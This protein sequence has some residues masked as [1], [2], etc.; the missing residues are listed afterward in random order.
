MYSRTIWKRRKNLEERNEEVVHLFKIK[1]NIKML[2][3]RF[4]LNYS[5]LHIL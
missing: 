5:T 4:R 3:K 2:P 1:L